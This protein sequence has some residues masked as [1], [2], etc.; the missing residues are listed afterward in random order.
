MKTTHPIKNSVLAAVL[1][2]AAVWALAPATVSAQEPLLEPCPT[3]LTAVIGTLPAIECTS[4]SGTDV[5]LDGTGSSVGTNITYLWTNDGGVTFDDDTSLTPMGTFA[6]G[7]TEVT[8]T[9]SCTD[10]IGTMDEAEMMDVVIQ[11]TTPPTL[12]AV[13][14]HACLW[15][16]N[17]KMHKIIV[18]AEAEDICDASPA[19]ILSSAVS[20]EPD[21]SNGDGNTVNDIHGADIGTDDPMFKLRSERRGPG[22][23][24]VYSITYTATDAAGNTTDDIVMI[25][26]PHDMGDA[27]AREACK[28][29]NVQANHGKSGMTKAEKNALKAEKQAAK[30][31]AK[32]AQKAA[33]AAQKAAKQAAKGSN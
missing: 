9:V 8:L 24:R 4:A 12:D 15:P 1:S 17:H 26:V 29:V 27:E 7:T 16:P 20:N 25:D 21:N 30:A 10:D 11:D 23:G 2:A 28:R 3:D 33:K 13:A 32:A 5:Q 19:V 14:D 6:L 18:T 22:S 31:A